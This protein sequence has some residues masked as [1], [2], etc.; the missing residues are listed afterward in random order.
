MK[1][2]KLIVSSFKKGDQI[3]FMRG[4]RN[5]CQFW[6]GGG[7]GGSWFIWHIKKLW[8]RFFIFSFFSP[9]LNLQK[10]SGYFQRELLFAKVPVG[11][12]IFQGGGGSNFLQGVQLLFPYRNPYNLWF[13]SGSGPPAPLWIRP[14][15]SAHRGLIYLLVFSFLFQYNLR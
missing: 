6:A 12:N 4:S 5:V 9:K 2:R 15:D 10:S 8:Q 11:W 3:W 1:T 13:S 14:C 7:G